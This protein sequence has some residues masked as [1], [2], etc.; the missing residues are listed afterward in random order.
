MQSKLKMVWES[1]RESPLKGRLVCPHVA[2]LLSHRPQ[3]RPR[4]LASGRCERLILLVTLHRRI[5]YIH[6]LLWSHPHF[7]R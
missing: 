6:C 5:P 4:L 7:P 2:L 1:A 3:R